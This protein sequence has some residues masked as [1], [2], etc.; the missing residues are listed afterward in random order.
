[1]QALQL[2]VKTGIADNSSQLHFHLKPFG[3]R[4]ITSFRINESGKVHFGKL[5]SGINFQT[6]LPCYA[7]PSVGNRVDA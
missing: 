3:A 4:L 2:Q 1:M 5:G 7:E 6:L